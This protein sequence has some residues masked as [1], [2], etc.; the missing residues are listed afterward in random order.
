MTCALNLVQPPS[1]PFVLGTER[2]AERLRGSGASSGARAQTRTV[3]GEA[4]PPVPLA[5]SS[6]VCQA[7]CG[8]LNPGQWPSSI[9]SQGLEEGWHRVREP[10]GARESS[11]TKTTCRGTGT[12]RGTGSL[13]PGPWAW[14]SQTCSPGGRA[15]REEPCECRDRA[16]CERSLW[17]RV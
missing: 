4:T 17:P 16:G 1:W 10:Q 3:Q 9:D 7:R 2:D 13:R 5:T 11:P 8:L 14:V 6:L 12:G 15:G